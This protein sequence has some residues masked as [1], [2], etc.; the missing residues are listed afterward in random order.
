MGLAAWLRLVGMLWQVAAAVE[1]TPWRRIRVCGRD[2]G[3]RQGFT[4][5]RSPWLPEARGAPAFSWGAGGGPR[6]QAEDGVWLGQEPLGPSLPWTSCKCC[7]FIWL[8]AQAA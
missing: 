1:V 3:R 6:L 2:G 4:E 8:S 7:E 5:Q